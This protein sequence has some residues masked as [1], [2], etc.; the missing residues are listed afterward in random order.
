M[1][2]KL[3]HVNINFEEGAGSFTHWQ[4]HVV[5]S[6]R[7]FYVQAKSWTE[8]KYVLL[9]HSFTKI[10]QTIIGIEHYYFFILSWWNSINC[11]FSCTYRWYQSLQRSQC[12]HLISLFPFLLGGLVA[13]HMTQRSSFWSFSMT[14][15]AFLF[16]V[17]LF[18]APSSVT[19]LPLE[20]E[21]TNCKNPYT[22]LCIHV[23]K[24]V[25]IWIW[26]LEKFSSK[27]LRTNQWI[28]TCQYSTLISYLLYLPL[29]VE[30][31]IGNVNDM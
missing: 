17:L 13:L 31:G 1:C 12:T 5:F 18:A 27:W 29:L 25:H 23:C 16:S 4:N 9:Y 30:L 6:W 14:S 15:P 26:L 19:C 22:G 24:V 28:T 10:Q 8:T 2:Y 21:I 7:G 3:V 11:Y 20:K